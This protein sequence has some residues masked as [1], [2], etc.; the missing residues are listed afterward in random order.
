MIPLGL[1]RTAFGL[2]VGK[3]ELSDRSRDGHTVRAR[4]L[5]LDHCNEG[6]LSGITEAVYFV[7]PFSFPALLTVR[8]L[9]LCL[10][11]DEG[12]GA[13]ISAFTDICP[14]AVE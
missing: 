14:D 13:R 12:R 8:A 2:S 3:R 7:A 4:G 10:S 1:S 9:S 6:V 5:M 11:T